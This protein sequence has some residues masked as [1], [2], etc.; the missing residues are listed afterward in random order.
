MDLVEI[1]WGGVDWMGL[2]QDRDRWRILEGSSKLSGRIAY[3][4]ILRQL[5]DWRLP[6]MRSAL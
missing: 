5:S 4:E 6:Q 2:A 1:G 3:W